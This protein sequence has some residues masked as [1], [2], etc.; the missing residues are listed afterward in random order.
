MVVG[1]TTA[2]DIYRPFVRNYALISVI[3][4]RDRVDGMATG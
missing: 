2:V 4:G 1:N 3:L